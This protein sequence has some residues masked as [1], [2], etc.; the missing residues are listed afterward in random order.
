VL[1]RLTFPDRVLKVE[2]R[3]IAWTDR[4]VLVEWG[5]GH[6]S[7]C[8]CVWVWRDAVRARITRLTTIFEA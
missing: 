6:A 8:A 7:E 3:V 2:A 4:A 5:F 1:A